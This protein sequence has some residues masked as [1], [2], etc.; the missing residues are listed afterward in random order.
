MA[1]FELPY[2]KG[3]LTLEIPASYPVD[4][5][6]PAEIAAAPDPRA[7]VDAALDRPVGAQTLHH[8]W[9][10][11]SV[12]IAIN[13]KT[14]PV[15]HADLLPPL[16][17]R[18]EASGIAPEAITLVIATGGHAPMSPDEFSAVV[19]RALLSRYRV[20]SH[21]CDDT[22][23]LV[24]LGKTAYGTPVWLNRH[25]RDA[26]LRIAVGNIEPHQFAGFSGGVK[27]VAIG[28]GGRATLTAN[29]A[30]LNEP[31]ARPLRFLDNPV[32]QD[33]EAIGRLAEI[34]FALNVVL[35]PHK[36]IGRALFGEPVAVMEAAIPLIRQ[37]YGVSIAAPYDLMV[38]SPGGYPKDLNLYQ[39]QKALAHA[40]LALNE[41][42]SAILVAACTEGLGSRTLSRWMTPDI[43]DYAAV[44]AKFHQEG[45]R[46]GA[47]KAVLIARDGRRLEHLWLVS[48]L[49]TAE[50]R[51]MLFVPTTLPEV[52]TEALDALPPGGRIGVM[53]LGNATIPILR[54]PS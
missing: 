7:A 33:I 5:I 16:L 52:L 17:A 26:E 29:H 22:E 32:R 15:P 30:M 6:A 40:S 45:F 43:S 14:R 8:F 41:G 12:A 19:P 24:F 28:L 25:F 10:A 48:E 1:T 34:H 2:A 20:I 49:P 4:V 42:G 36:T 31:R 47:H 3:A 53:P 39:A 11:R 37:V 23:Q 54:S 50:A 18:L 44:F 38:I 13:D 35:T 46:L 21:D 51:R 9:G 27:S